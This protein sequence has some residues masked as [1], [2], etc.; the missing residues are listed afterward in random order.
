M[1]VTI[2]SRGPTHSLVRTM[3]QALETLA[4]IHYSSTISQRLFVFSLNFTI[5]CPSHPTL[6]KF[7]PY[8]KSISPLSSHPM[9]PITPLQVG[10]RRIPTATMDCGGPGLVAESAP[11]SATMQSDAHGDFGA[12]L[13]WR[14]GPV[15]IIHQ[16]LP[17]QPV[18]NQSLRVIISHIMKQK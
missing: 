18:T 11:S 1:S 8:F 2:Q 6:R 13:M 9:H 16:F 10:Y 3:N 4:S 17:E 12:M 15:R 14:A 7:L 5:Q